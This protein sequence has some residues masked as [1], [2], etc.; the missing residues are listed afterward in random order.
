M[1][2]KWR[3]ATPLHI[4][5]TDDRYK[6]ALKQ[7]K[8]R[9]FSDDETW[10]LASTIAEFTLPRLKRFKRI[11]P[12]FPGCF[13]HMEEWDEILDKMIIAL[14]AIVDDDRGDEQIEEGLA[15]FG[16]YFMGLWW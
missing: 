5:R 4:K 2:S 11:K 12:G 1:I 10:D 14:T 9:G 8:T 15:L 6:K 16:K 7:L 3:R 13:D